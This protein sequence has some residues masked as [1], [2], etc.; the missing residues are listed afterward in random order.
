MGVLL[1]TELLHSQPGCLQGVDFNFHFFDLGVLRAVHCIFLLR[2]KDVVAI[3][4]AGL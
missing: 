2:K 3:P 1:L 4:N